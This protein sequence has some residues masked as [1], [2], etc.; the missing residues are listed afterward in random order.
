MARDLTE[1]V[2]ELRFVPRCSDT[3][4]GTL[5]TLCSGA[6][7]VGRAAPVEFV[8][9]AIPGRTMLCLSDLSFDSAQDRLREA[10]ERLEQMFRVSSSAGLSG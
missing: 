3:V 7:C 9:P 5:P 4:D 2:I 6:E 10:V 8:P 1:A